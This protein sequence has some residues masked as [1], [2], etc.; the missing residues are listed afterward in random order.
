MITFNLESRYYNNLY[1]ASINKPNFKSVPLNKCKENSYN[2]T[3]FT[4]RLIPMNV[5]EASQ[6]DIG[7]SLQKKSSALPEVIDS[8]FYDIGLYLKKEV[9]QSK[10]I[11]HYM[12]LT[13]P[14]YRRVA[15]GTEKELFKESYAPELKM[16]TEIRDTIN[17]IRTNNTINS[18]LDNIIVKVSREYLQTPIKRKKIFA[19]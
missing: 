7:D 16:I 14:L 4:G 18:E 6:F 5:K 12:Q 19:V 9:S 8:M 3:I 10:F 17:S 15:E 1:K 11:E 13:E 2:N